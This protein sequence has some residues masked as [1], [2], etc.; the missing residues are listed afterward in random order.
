MVEKEA[1][2]TMNMCLELL[3]NDTFPREDYKELV[4]LT[5]VWLGGVSKV[6]NFKFQWPGAFHLARFMAKNLYILKMDLLK[7]QIRFLSGEEREQISQLAI[8]VGVYFSRWFLKCAV[9]PSAPKL[10]LLS[11]NQMLDFSVFDPGLAFTVL[12]S[13]MVLDRGV[14]GSVSC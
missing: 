4:E 11:I 9:A 3:D 6:S 13:I 8:F 2:E 12:D 14:G 7:N 10:A 1:R 5:L